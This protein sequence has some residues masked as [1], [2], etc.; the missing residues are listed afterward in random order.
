MAQSRDEETRTV[1]SDKT[2]NIKSKVG[3]GGSFK[4]LFSIDSLLNTSNSP[5]LADEQKKSEFEDDSLLFRSRSAGEQADN[6]MTSSRQLVTSLDA[7]SHYKSGT[8]EMLMV[9]P[10]PE[11]HLPAQI[12][13]GWPASNQYSLVGGRNMFMLQGKNKLILTNSLLTI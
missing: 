12:P 13:Y 10:R 2:S 3:A 11:I 6:C 9:S 5:T 4:S 1:R 7:S 8:G